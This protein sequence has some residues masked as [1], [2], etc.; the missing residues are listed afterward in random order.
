M[1]NFIMVQQYII[2]SAP[3]PTLGNK[4]GKPLPFYSD[5]WRCPNRFDSGVYD[6]N[7]PDPLCI[8]TQSICTTDTQ[9]EH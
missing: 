5:F 7:Q 3:G 4:Y 6:T 2:V 8:F 9:T 1:S